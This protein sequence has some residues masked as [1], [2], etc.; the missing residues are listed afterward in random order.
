[1]VGILE[2]KN[3]YF[4]PKFF[5]DSYFLLITALTKLKKMSLYPLKCASHNESLTEDRGLISPWEHSS[6]SHAMHVYKILEMYFSY[7]CK[8]SAFFKLETF[9]LS[10]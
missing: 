1:V 10:F 5:G 6:Y 2:L 8:I 3:S 4:G 7:N 9:L